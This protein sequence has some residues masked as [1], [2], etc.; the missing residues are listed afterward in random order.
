VSVRWRV[1][2]VVVA[3]LALAPVEALAQNRLFRGLFRAS[4][5]P[6]ASR[7]QL[8]AI[9]T[10]D[11]GYDRVRYDSTLTGTLE[12]PVSVSAT[13][14]GA[15][16]A[17]SYFHRGNRVAF[18]ASGGGYYRSYSLL[19]GKSFP[20]FFQQTRFTAKL[21]PRTEL[22]LNQGLTHARFYGYN[23]S[24]NADLEPD[25]T[26]DL[27]PDPGTLVEPENEFFAERRSNFVYTGGAEVMH[28]F[29]ERATFSTTVSGR[30]V[31]FRDE[32]PDAA[33]WRAAVRFNRRM[34]QYATVRMGYAFS[35]W[36]YPQFDVRLV[37]HD[38][39]A[40]VA[41]SRPL[42]MSRRTRVGFDLSSAIADAPDS[43]R[44]RINGLA[45]VSHIVSRDWVTSAL[46][47]RDNEVIEGF[48][49]PFFLF[50]D[51]VG[52]SLTGL[53]ARR[54]ALSFSGSY[55]YGRYDIGPIENRSRWASGSV[56]ARATLYRTLAGYVQGG[57]GQYD[58]DRRFG[59]YR[60][61]PLSNNRYWVRAG[62]VLGLPLIT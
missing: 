37:S 57:T 25:D 32:S 35:T 47:R 15:S 51:S 38:I 42:P 22:R 30:Y 24:V 13:T 62:V 11:F 45:F 31:D 61:T 52:G 21:T 44:F 19:P 5:D 55:S 6:A 39:N 49:V 17:L 7:D 26:E 54:V 41:Y 48:A 36:R 40:G 56:L 29:S 14:P 60:T 9:V 58:F 20:S 12:R 4:E 53:V 27:V 43:V 50:S 2:A 59:L 8:F 34:T 1:A 46:Y 23:R 33:S 18:A 10:G 28:R 16:A 3:A